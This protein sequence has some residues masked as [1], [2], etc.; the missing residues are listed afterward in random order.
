MKPKSNLYAFGATI[1]AVLCVLAWGFATGWAEDKHEDCD[2]HDHSEGASVV[3]SADSHEGHDHEGEDA[4]D[5][6]GHDHATEPETA[7]GHDHDD[8]LIVELTPEAARLA[9][10]RTATVA[11]G[12][13]ATELGLPGEVSL[14]E[15][16]LVHVS[17]RFAGI[18]LDVHCRLGDYVKAGHRMAT[19]ESNESMNSYTIE[20]PM[21]GWVIDRNVSRGEFVSEES[22]IF[23]IADLSTVW[24]NLAVYP[25]DC[26]QI[27]RGQTVSIQAVGSSTSVRGEIDYIS[28]IMNSQ[29]RSAMA[30]VTL[31]NPN[32]IWRPGTFVQAVVATEGHEETLAVERDAVQYLDEEQVVFVTDGP[33]RYRPAVVVTGTSDKR[34]TQILNGLS[35]GDE[36]VSE[37]AFEL[38]AKIV[39]SNLDAHAGH[40]H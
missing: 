25:K 31:P 40:G 23:T 7:D 6:S 4:E 22:S 29:T 2:G 38:K 14:N 13:I 15:D 10:L 21:S 34:L 36:Y 19:I 3:E 16:N 39:T 35:E 5:H 11:H 27:R 17:P 26:H 18:A 9:G 12:Q 30:R 28:P 20:A 1:C 32:N 37:G 8:E 24:V 33:G